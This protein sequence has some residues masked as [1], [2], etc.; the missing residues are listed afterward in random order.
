MK[1]GDYDEFARL[2]DDVYDMISCGQKSLSGAAKAIFFRAVARFPLDVFRA[3]L[4][5]HVMSPAGKYLP[6][7]A[8]IVEQ[9]ELLKQADGRPGAEEAW[10]NAL[11]AED[12]QNTVI[13]TKEA[14]AAFALARPVLVSSGPISARMTFLE[15][16]NRLVA[17]ARAAGEPVQWSASVGWDKSHAAIVLQQAEQKGLLPAPSVAVLLPGRASDVPADESARAQLAKIK[18]MLKGA[19]EAREARRIAAWEEREATDRARRQEIAA[20]VAQYQGVAA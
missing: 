8:H 5:A 3:A 15:A 6:Q 10:A 18:E 13:W 9:V 19:D 7:P 20:Q 12:E 16:Y 11:Q 2:I 17:A 1:Q 14:G 4:H